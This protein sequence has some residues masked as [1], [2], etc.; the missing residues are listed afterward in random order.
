HAP[1]L[2]LSSSLFFTDTPSSQISTLSLHDALPISGADFLMSCRTIVDRLGAKSCPIQLPIGA[3]S[4]F[5]GIV[6]IIERKAEIYTN[7]LGT[8]IKV[9]DV[10][11]D[12]KDLRS[13]ERRVGREG[14]DRG[15]ARYERRRE[16]GEWGRKSPESQ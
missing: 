5:T 2:T 11:E 4:T 9:E 7:D 13:E 12:L 3:E 1:R 10:P 15:A 14:R 16:Y 6:D 8:D